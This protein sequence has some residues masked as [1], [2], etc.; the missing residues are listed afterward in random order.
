MKK[1]I[2]ISCLSSNRAI[3]INNNLILNLKYDMKFF[4]NKTVYVNN[5]DCKNA[6]IMGRKTYNNI[7]VLGLN[8]RANCVISNFPNSNYEYNSITPRKNEVKFFNNIDLCLDTLQNR[9][10]IE[11]IYVIGGEKIY[12]YFMDNHIYDELFIS[13]ILIF[14]TP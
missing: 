12:Q 14:Q 1:I 9:K 11:S 2:G 6:V 4:K 8:E 3:G 13:Y 5:K 7:G 10:D